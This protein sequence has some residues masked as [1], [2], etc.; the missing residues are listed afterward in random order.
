V[1]KC[2]LWY[3]L[4][5]VVPNKGYKTIVVVVVVVVVVVKML[6]LLLCSHNKQ[7][8]VRNS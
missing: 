4:S 1:G 3:W 5:W 6:K 7:P 8:R 2:F